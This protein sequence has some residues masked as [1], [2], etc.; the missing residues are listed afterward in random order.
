MRTFLSL[1]LL[2]LLVAISQGAE[3]NRN[4]EPL[5]AVIAKANQVLQKSIEDNVSVVSEVDAVFRAASRLFKEGQ[6]RASQHYFIAGLQISPWD[7]DRQLE[8]AK[9]LLALE[10]Q[11]K[12]QSVARL[13]LQT[14]ERQKLLEES[15]E[16]IGESLPQ[17]I[18][19]VPR[20]PIKETVICFVRIGPIEDWIIQKSGRQLSEK[21][22]VPVY[23]HTEQLPLPL[24]HRSYYERWSQ[25]I[26]RNIVWDHPYVKEQMKDIGIESK[27]KATT[28]QTLE[29][30][31][32]LCIAQGE[33]DPR[34]KFM[35][36]KRRTKERDKQWDA[37]RLLDDLILRI[38]RNEKIVYVGVTAE[39]I[40]ANN[41]NYIFGTA[42]IGKRYCLY[43]YRRY[44]AWFNAER[45]N[46]KRLLERIHK[47]LL[48]S[49][50]FALGIERP[51]DPR[52]ARSYPHNLEDHDLKGTWL[53]LECI[54]G[55][56]K[57]LGHPL[58]EKTKEESK[59]ALQQTR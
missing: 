14:S 36:Y 18:T 19:G 17:H 10:N 57:A 27:E 38:P 33:D 16:L 28:D 26:K 32:R 52:S 4:A 44:T 54:E 55:F 42:L 7:M 50:G 25:A 24:P 21:L 29:L 59:K 3:D 51:T 11:E 23:V 37:D 45:E 12:A 5:E 34:D 2:L 20:T 58:P 49:V 15:A 22:G 56:E 31:A 46:Q 1:L 35:E 8:Y 30:M 48:S 43:S 53:S 40:Y 39:D 41:D 6:F 13:V 47:Q 9:V